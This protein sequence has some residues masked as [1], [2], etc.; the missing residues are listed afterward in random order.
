M[1]LNSAQQTPKGA[2]FSITRQLAP[3]NSSIPPSSVADDK[4]SQ[5]DEYQ[6]IWH[7]ISKSIAPTNE[8]N[9]ALAK[10]GDSCT[11]PVEDL[12]EDT[13]LSTYRGNLL[14]NMS[15]CPSNLG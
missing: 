5:G 1:E 2:Y 12:D 11:Y 14:F 3:S 8:S 13:E 15:L 4:S 10:D 7:E 6:C 9:S